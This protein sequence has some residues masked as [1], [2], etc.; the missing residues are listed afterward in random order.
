[1]TH[2]NTAA[3]KFAAEDILLAAGKLSYHEL[4]HS[5]VPHCRVIIMRDIREAAEEIA[6]WL[7]CDLVPKAVTEAPGF[8]GR[9]NTAML[10][11]LS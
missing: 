11:D 7:G 6:D 4:W 3:I 1:M 8:D 2:T 9:D 10:G 5:E